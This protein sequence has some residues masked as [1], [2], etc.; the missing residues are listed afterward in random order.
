MKKRILCGHN[1]HREPFRVLEDQ[2]DITYPEKSLFKKEEILSMIADYDIF[3]PNFTFQTD[4]EIIDKGVKLK[5]ISNYGVG[6]NNIDTQYAAS[7]GIVVT[8][9]PYSVLEPTAELCFCL[10]GDVARKTGFYNNKLRTPEGLSWGVYDNPGITMYGKTLGIFGFGRIGQS[11]ARRA[12]AGGMNI[13][14]HNR[15]KVSAD[16]ENL[17]KARYV[18]F[19]ELLTQS[20]ILSINAPATKET[21]HIINEEAISKMKP[22]A[23]LINTS[24]GVTVDEKALIKALQNNRIWGAGLDVYETE[25]KINPDFLT[26]DN[27]VLTPHAGTLTIEARYDMQ[28]EI[29]TNI[30]NFYNGGN[31]SRVN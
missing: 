7:K 14:Y 8:N 29:A 25:P 17:Y 31:I 12:I 18:S 1:F 9:T 20:D 6:Y 15:S 4:K 2:F 11:V 16:I 13:I 27:V 3:I 22:T 21:Y 19:E 5:L 30:L 10:M 23:I 24:R 26:L 28:S